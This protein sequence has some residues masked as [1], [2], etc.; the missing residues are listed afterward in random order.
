[1]SGRVTNQTLVPK[2]TVVLSFLYLL[3]RAFLESSVSQRCTES[4]LSLKVKGSRPLGFSVAPF[5][6]LFLSQ[7]ACFGKAP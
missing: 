4:L 3:I 6:I 7:Y 2:G 5:R 1:M